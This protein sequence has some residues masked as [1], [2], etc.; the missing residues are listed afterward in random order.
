VSGGIEDILTPTRREAL[1]KFLDLLVKLNESGILDTASDIVDPDVIGRLSEILLR[2]STLQILDHLDE[3]LDAMGQVKPETLTKS[4]A[5]LGTVLEAMEKE[6]KP[7][8]IP[9]LLKA[10]SDPEVQKGLGVALE[11]L[12]ALGRSHKK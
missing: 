1:E 6:A 4:F 5:T 3:I 9:G 11:V 7:V 12:R 2:P 8:G 10:L